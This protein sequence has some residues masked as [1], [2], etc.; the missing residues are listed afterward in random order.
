VDDDMAEAMGLE[1]T[2]G[3]LVTDVP[4]GPAK[5]AGIEAGDVIVNFDGKD[6]EDTRSL[7]RTVGNTAVGKAVRVVVFREGKT[8]TLMITLGRKEEAEAA[9]V[10]AVA[11]NEENDTPVEKDMLGL[12]L[13]VLNDAMREQMD[14]NKNLEGLVVLNVDEASEAFEKGLR[15]GDVITEAG[16]QK[17]TDISMLDARIAD[18]KDAGRKSILLLIRR[19]GDPR[20]VALS[21]E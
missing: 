7:V 16:Q 15:A 21:L 14:L 10:P 11:Q 1:N 13:S 9:A 18:A 2:A 12:T 6:V 19:D 5:D 3:A 8:Q 4:D 17:L 20:F